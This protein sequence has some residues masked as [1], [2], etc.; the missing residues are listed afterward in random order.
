MFLDNSSM[1]SI[2]ASPHTEDITGNGTTNI[3]FGTELG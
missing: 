1:N 2:G 3:I